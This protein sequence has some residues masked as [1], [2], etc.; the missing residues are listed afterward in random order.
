MILTEDRLRPCWDQIRR[1]RLRRYLGPES[2]GPWRGSIRRNSKEFTGDGC[3]NAGCDDT[4]A[5][6]GGVRRTM[7]GGEVVPP[8]AQLS[9]QKSFASATRGLDSCIRAAS[10]QCIS[11]MPSMPHSASPKCMGIPAKVLPASTSKRNKDASRVLMCL[12]TLLK[13]ANQS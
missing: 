10:Q 6:G 11:I 4:E 3:V 13:N 7:F 2:G 8:L 5:K 1:A 9:A 12:S